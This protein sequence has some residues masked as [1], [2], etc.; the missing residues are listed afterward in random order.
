MNAISIV[1]IISF[2]PPMFVCTHTHMYMSFVSPKLK[3]KKD[4]A[5]QSRAELF[6]FTD[7]KNHGAL[8]V[9]LSLCQWASEWVSKTSVTFYFS[10]LFPNQTVEKRGRAIIGLEC[11]AIGAGPTWW[12]SF[13]V[14]VNPEECVGPNK[15]EQM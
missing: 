1:K 11:V 5:Q 3:I 6:I 10:I 14:F 8:W 9:A 2:F 7:T 13:A 12:L 15:E 4:P